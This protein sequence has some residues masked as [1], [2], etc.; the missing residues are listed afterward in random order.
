MNLMSMVILDRFDL[1]VAPVPLDYALVESASEIRFLTLAADTALTS[2]PKGV[3]F[4]VDSEL[5]WVQR[6]SG[7]WHFVLLD[8]NGAALSGAQAQRVVDPDHQQNQTFQTIFLRGK[9][10]ANGQILEGSIPRPL[11]YPFNVTGD[12]PRLKVKHYRFDEETFFRLVRPA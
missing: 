7:Q 11:Q 1:K 4:S 3:A 2:F 9:K 8:D 12:R 10:E 5:R 6:Q